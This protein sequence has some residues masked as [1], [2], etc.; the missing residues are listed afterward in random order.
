MSCVYSYLALGERVQL[1]V[2]I[3]PGRQRLV[4]KDQLAVGRGRFGVSL[5]SVEG[6]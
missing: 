2:V 4:G 1:S 6:R 3:D 5:E